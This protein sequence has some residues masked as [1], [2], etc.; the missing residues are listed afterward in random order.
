MRPAALRLLAE[1]EADLVV[2][3]HPLPFC[4]VAR[5][6][7]EAGGPPVVGFTTD[8]VI[9]HALNVSPDVDHYAVASDLVRKQLEARGGPW[10]F[11]R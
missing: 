8:L 3:F 6:A 10:K 2:V 7:R 1:N 4:A 9:G 11:M 5:A